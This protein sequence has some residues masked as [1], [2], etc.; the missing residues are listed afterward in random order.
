MARTKNFAALLPALATPLVLGERPRPS[1]KDG[2][3]LVRNHAIA[4]NP[5]D[6]KRQATGF[7]IEKYPAIL[8]SGTHLLIQPV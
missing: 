8:G 4:L 5:V 2:E 1:P 7:G 3:I 6:W